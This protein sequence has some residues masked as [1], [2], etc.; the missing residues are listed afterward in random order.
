[1]TGKNI[2][3]T[4]ET[5]TKENPDKYF[6]LK[7][8]NIPKFIIEYLDTLYPDEEYIEWLKSPNEVYG[9]KKGIQLFSELNTQKLRENLDKF[10]TSLEDIFYF[11][12]K[13]IENFDKF[14]LEVRNAQLNQILG[15]GR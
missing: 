1:M 7:V 9:G 11:C 13:R 3:E 2:D 4:I 14:Y 12:G 8:E 15:E 10:H 6:E 5:Y